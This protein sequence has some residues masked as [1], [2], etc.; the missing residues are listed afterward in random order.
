MRFRVLLTVSILF[1]T[2]LSIK[3]I[4]V[5]YGALKRE[6]KGKNDSIS[7]LRDSIAS[8]LEFSPENVMSYIEMYDILHPNAVYKQT[9]LET[10]HFKS[11]VF[12]RN[13]NLFGMKHP[14]SRKTTSLGDSLGYAYYNNYIES[15]KDYKLYQ[16]RYYK[17]GDYYEF[18]R[19]SGYSEDS[20][21]T[22]KVKRQ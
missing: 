2:V 6:I 3:Y 10:G 11:N 15:I 13:N 16:E 7:I 22:N 17:K 8:I 5:E 18:L 14:Y 20:L 1:A 19:K 9:L 4:E 21:Y 12:S